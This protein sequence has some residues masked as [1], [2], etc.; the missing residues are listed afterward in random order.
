VA[1]LL[2]V[3]F[4]AFLVYSPVTYGYKPLFNAWSSLMP[5]DNIRK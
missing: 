5:L 4:V 2:G 1:G 3:A